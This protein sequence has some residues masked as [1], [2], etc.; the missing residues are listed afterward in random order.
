VIL[1]WMP[2]VVCILTLAMIDDIFSLDRSAG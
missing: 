1:K 2:G